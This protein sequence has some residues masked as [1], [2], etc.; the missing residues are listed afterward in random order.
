[1]VNSNLSSYAYITP[2]VFEN[3][4]QYLCITVIDYYVTESFIGDSSD[5]PSCK[6]KLQVNMSILFFF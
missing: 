6:S 3:P 5:Q 2:P 1:M 4:P